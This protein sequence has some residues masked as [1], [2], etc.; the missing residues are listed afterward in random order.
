MTKDE[1]IDKLWESS[2]HGTDRV[3]VEA[4]YEAGA[5]AERE[6]CA[7][8]CDQHQEGGI[9]GWKHNTPMDCAAAIRARGTPPVFTL[10]EQ[11]TEEEIAAIKARGAQP[12]VFNEIKKGGTP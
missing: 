5:A 4:A 12:L 9:G 11:W 7:Q 6:A 1:A 3:D 8:V 10:A 2:N